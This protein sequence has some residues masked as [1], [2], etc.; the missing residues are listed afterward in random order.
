MRPGSAVWAEAG[1]SGRTSNAIMQ[2]SRLIVVSLF[3]EAMRAKVVR[4]RHS[5]LCFADN[6]AAT[7]RTGV[8]QKWPAPGQSEAFDPYRTSPALLPARCLGA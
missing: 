6:L 4:M 3:A 8:D 7:H 1:E 2:L 5:C